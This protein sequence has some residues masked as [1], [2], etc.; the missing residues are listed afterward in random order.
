MVIAGTGSMAFGSNTQG[1]T[2]RAGGWGYVYGDD[3]GAFDLVRQAMRASLQLEE[4]WGSPTSLRGVLLSATGAQTISDLLHN[5]YA[6]YP[7]TAV[8]ALAPLISKESAAGDP[9][10]TEIVEKAARSL[11][12]FVA[13][14]HRN[15]FSSEELVPVA[16]VGGVFTDPQIRGAFTRL[17]ADAIPC[18]VQPPFFSPVAGALLQALRADHN[19]NKLR[20]LPPSVK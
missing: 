6:D 10:A 13:G 14:V 7:R 16:H 9:V 3:G 15:L 20:G 11:T 4:G 2:A 18:K 1:R 19:P 8:A 5:F 17:V 12:W